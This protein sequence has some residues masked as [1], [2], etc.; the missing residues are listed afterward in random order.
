MRLRFS[1]SEPSK[2]WI[3]S[4]PVLM[5]TIPVLPAWT[6]ERAEPVLAGEGATFDGATVTLPPLAYLWLSR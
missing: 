5:L 4:E 1:V 3:A 6:L 2:V